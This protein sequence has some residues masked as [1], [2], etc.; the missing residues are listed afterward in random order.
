MFLNWS[1]LKRQK[2]LYFFI[3]RKKLKYLIVN[4][5]TS[6]LSKQID[7]IYHTLK[8]KLIRKYLLKKHT[9]YK[10]IRNYSFGSLLLYRF[11][12]NQ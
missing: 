4:L 9:L 12:N 1:Y 11:N 5:K 2:V 6:C 7:I 3:F 10:T 8:S